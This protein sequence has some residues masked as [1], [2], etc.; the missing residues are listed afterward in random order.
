MHDLTSVDPA[1]HCVSLFAPFSDLIHLARKSVPVATWLKTRSCECSGCVKVFARTGR[2][3]LPFHAAYPSVVCVDS[4]DY[5]R[6]G[7]K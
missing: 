7:N 3:G 4:A 2:P 1:Y 6:Q 5:K